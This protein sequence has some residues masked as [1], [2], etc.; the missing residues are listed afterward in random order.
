MIEPLTND[1]LQI[2]YLPSLNYAMS[3]NG[4]RCIERLEI[5]NNDN[6]DWH[7]VTVSV[8]GDMLVPSSETTTIIPGG[9]TV[10]F[11]QLDI[12]PNV[13][14][15][16]QLTESVDTQFA[17]SISIDGQEV[18][19]KHCPLRLM[20]FNEWP[21]LG[22]MPELLASFVTPNAPELAP[23]KVHAA[24]H[25][26]R[27]TGQSSLDDYQ[28]QDPNRA[29][30]QV[31]AIYEALRQES[32]VYCTLPASFESSGQRIRLAEEILTTRMATC[33][34][35]TLLF[36]SCLES[37]GLHPL[38]VMLKGHAYVACWLIDNYYQQMVGDDVS[39]L[40]KTIADGINEMVVVETT[41]ITQNGVDFESAVQ[42]A[43]DKLYKAPEQ[44]VA[45]V[46]IHRCR[47][48]GVRPLPLR[49]NGQWMTNGLEHDTATYDIRQQTRLDVVP[50]GPQGAATR[51]QIWERKLLDFSLRNN[52]LN[53]RVGK[54]LIPFISFDI[55]QLEDHLQAGEDYRITPTPTK[56]QLAADEFGIYNSKAHRDELEQLVTENLKHNELVSY[57]T[58]D[59]LLEAL[60]GLYR[61]SRTAL[62]ENGANSLFLVLGVLKWF[63]T[64]KSIRPRFAPL[65]LLPVD[66]I[67]K[68]GNNYIIRT[69]DEDVT[70]NTTLVEMLRQQHDINLSGLMPLPT[71]ENGIDVKTVFATIRALL[72]DH[73]RWDV[74]EE[75]M[76]GLFSF[77]KF[78]M[79]NDIHNNAEKMRQSAVIESLL[80][81]RLVDVGNIT[82]TDT[83]NIDQT[84]TPANYAI[85]VD[86]DSSQLEAVIESGEGRSFILYG[87]PGTGK[88]QTITNMIANALYHDKRVLFV[89]EKMAALQVVQKRLEK[90]GLGPFSLEL[91]SNKVTRAHLLQQLQQ[92]LD[93][94][95]I[96]SPDE[97]EAESQALFDQRRQLVEIM[98]RLHVS[99]AS[100]LSLYD[101]ITRYL[102]IDSDDALAPAEGY[103]EGLNA[104]RLSDDEQLV[105]QLDVVFAVTG[106]PANH[107]LNGLN[108]TDVSAAAKQR[109][110]DSLIKIQPELSAVKR[111]MEAIE[112]ECH[113]EVPHTLSGTVWTWQ[114]VNAVRQIPVLN[115]ALLDIAAN[116][117]AEGQWRQVVAT[118]MRRDE[119]FHAITQHYLVEIVQ[120]DPMQLRGEW[121]AACDKWF[122]PR[123]F[124]K[125][126][127]LKQ[128]KVYRPDITEAHVQPL[129][130]QLYEYRQRAVAVDQVTN[131]LQALFGPLARRGAEQ[132]API[133]QTLDSAPEVLR[134]LRAYRRQEGTNAFNVEAVRQTDISPIERM[135]Q[136][137]AAMGDVCTLDPTLTLDEMVTKMPLWLAHLDKMRDWTQWCL[138]KNQLDDRHLSQ[139]AEFIEKGRHTSDEAADAMLKGTYHRMGTDIIDGD[140]QLQLFNGLIFEDAIQRYRDMAKNF[141][142]LTKKALY[143]RLASHIPSQTFQAST[144]SEMGILKR[145]I[146]SGGRGTTIRHIIDQVPT[147]LPKLCPCMLMSPLSVA[148]FIDLDQEK[149]DIVVFD[150]ASQMP[151]SEAIGAIARGKA[152]IVVGDPK[153]MPPTSFFA[154]QQTDESDAE[155]DDMES[156]LDDCITLSLPAHY[157]TWH[158]RSRHE[159]LIAFSNSQYYDG[160]LFTFPSVDDRLSKVR[161]IPIDG[162]YDMGKTR[163]NRSEA[164]AIVKET[165][166][167]LADPE[168]SK[169]SIGIVSFS[170]VQQD[171]IEDILTDELA[172]KPELEAK[173]YDS[174]EPIFIKNLE[175]VQ[176]DE[177]DVILFSIGYGPDKRGHVSMNFG[178]LNN[179]GG[180]RRLNVAVSRARYE[181]MV[182]STLQ[183]EQIDL[184][185]SRAKGV[186]GLKRFLE[187]AKNGRIAVSTTQVAQE[188]GLDLADDIAREIRKM[189]YE[190]DTHVGRSNFKVDVAV[191]DPDHTDSYLLGILCDGRN[192][193]ETKTER[194]REI[195][196]PGVLRGLGWNLLRIWSVDW[197]MNRDKDLERIRQRLDELKS[198]GGAVAVETA[199]AAPAPKIATL[200]PF[201]VGE[202]EII[203]DMTNEHEKPYQVGNYRMLS[204]YSTFVDLKQ[205]KMEG[206]IHNI[207]EAEQPITLSLICKR[208]CSIYGVPRVTPTIRQYVED[209][210]NANAY[211]DP[212]SPRS[213]PYYWKD[214]TTAIHYANYRQAAGRDADDIP[215]VEVR[216]LLAYAI[217]Q[218]VSTPN[219][220][221]LRSQVAKV[222]G[223]TRRTK[224]L[225]EL[226]DLAVRQLIVCG[227]ITEKDG[228][229]S[230]VEG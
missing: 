177:R 136:A 189:G 161:F 62:E 70:F 29:R 59:D 187:F 135:Q 213:N 200:M 230:Y 5:T 166:R 215:V 184:N 2:D 48:N 46:D 176:G 54:K 71:D 118:G 85:P 226:V 137:L 68:S 124:A 63:E 158:Y 207:V 93:L 76:L 170:K 206:V 53:L 185:R 99:R 73:P 168:L 97:Y 121:Q 36:A 140:S 13:D 50:E 25:L 167:R 51:Q 165:L 154:V 217:E 77:S 4:K 175:N 11:T 58:D 143:C 65:I 72:K 157:L 110:L 152:L 219:D 84:V 211:R 55:D 169:L 83:R 224:K 81:K 133:T 106:H 42:Q 212:S 139:V 95:R 195:T 88:S 160:R 30:A 6:S 35:S 17:V 218:Q 216:N 34:D 19:V 108:T 37:C 111:S 119:L 33:L 171:L 112:A 22:I 98:E 113:V 69:R 208:I 45:F 192:Y 100:G 92:A 178:P 197:F 105:R 23:I 156:I 134:L 79:W 141:Q 117:T 12:Q 107:P 44:F 75:A 15:L 21:G 159:S 82:P 103:M 153:Q 147:L 188:R 130:D 126:K 24:S 102:S 3:V 1:Q 56:R 80:Q 18:L 7:D 129:L 43:E 87:P 142:E 191:I 148:Q 66:I 49:V 67:R 91:H 94:T 104:Q 114:F 40:T 74:V 122:I 27:L 199:N 146:A 205:K 225:D 174:A 10:S 172:K 194:D 131:D 26:E 179:Q 32:I 57:L 180:E 38:V 190:V 210:V 8:S 96:K 227:K 115:A 31:A 196:Q 28:T 14:Q 101:I 164:E 116:A 202:D 182:F 89:A 16:R 78:V 151:T 183:P 155:N 9:K 90:I 41:C 60:K 209:K 145:Y 162:T 138:R 163:C 150:E 181:M 61:A 201:A 203:S 229:L 128:M 125:R 39:F 47:L 127:F 186:E 221:A 223:F 204:T 86:V 220:A 109:V 173:A 228:V 64:P 222:L 149:F 214:A 120:R 144:N 198:E 20:A 123:F 193:Y 52:L 132:W